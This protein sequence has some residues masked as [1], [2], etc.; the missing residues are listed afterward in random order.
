M[1]QLTEERPKCLVE[2]HGR[3]LLKWQIDSLKEA[4]IT[5]IAIVTGYER[6]QLQTWGLTEFHNPRWAETNMVS[7]LAS[8]S[9]WLEEEP[10]IVSYSDIV[11]DHSAVS[12]LEESDAAIAITYDPDW[13]A[14]W[15]KRFDD[16]LEDAETFQL[17]TDGFVNNIGD[18]PT[19]VDEVE[20]QYMGL[21]RIAPKGWSE[22]T[23]ILS[24]LPS[25]RRDNVHMT[26][27]LQ[28]VIAQDRVKIT[29]LP[30]R[31]KWSEVDSESD[32][33]VAEELM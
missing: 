18:K 23:I 4:G 15:E 3:P 30:Y 24:T 5:D 33:R 32:L 7:S 6:E 29:G 14:K 26:G 27:M 13:Q 11:Y 10:C 25:D 1:N 28:H 17:N 8:A 12:M 16:P 22:I 19:S 31:G 9:E 2:L 20:G 21:L